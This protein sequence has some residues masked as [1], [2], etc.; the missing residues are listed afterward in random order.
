[1]PLFSEIYN[2]FCASMTGFV[3]LSVFFERIMKVLVCKNWRSKEKYLTLHPIV[4]SRP[5]K[6][7]E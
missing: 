3:S 4:R 2:H 6:T 7:N 1:M 5:T